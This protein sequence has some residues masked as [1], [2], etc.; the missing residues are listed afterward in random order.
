VVTRFFESSFTRFLLSCAL[1]WILFVLFVCLFL[2]FWFFVFTRQGFSVKPW[3][4][5]NL[6]CR[7]KLTSNS[8]GRP[9]APPAPA[10]QVCMPPSPPS[11]VS[12]FLPGVLS[13]RAL[14]YSTRS[15]S[16]Y[17]LVHASCLS[18]SLSVCS[19]RVNPGMERW[20]SSICCSRGLEF[21]GQ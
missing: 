4:V 17:Y 7:T 12:A 18:S 10:S 16:A 20:L 6:F 3:L 5:W 15:C 11:L 19:E 2:V 8:P 13:W 21:E 1:F 14:V 9:R